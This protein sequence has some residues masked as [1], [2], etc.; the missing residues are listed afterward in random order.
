MNCAA[1]QEATSRPIR[2]W[3]APVLPGEVGQ[4]RQDQAE[5][6]QVDEDDEKDVEKTR[7]FHTTSA[8]DRSG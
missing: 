3:L 8:M 6:Q 5:A 1:A 4:Q 7:T 2:N